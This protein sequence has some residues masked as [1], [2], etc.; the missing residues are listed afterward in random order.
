M[1]RFNNHL[2]ESVPVPQYVLY[3]EEGENLAG[4]QDA[5]TASK[6]AQKIQVYLPHT[7][8]NFLSI[9][10]DFQYIAFAV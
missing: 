10:D 8:D 5:C 9:V 3:D 2:D 7:D 1:H 4:E 6:I